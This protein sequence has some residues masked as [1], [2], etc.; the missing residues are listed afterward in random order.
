MFRYL[1][2]VIRSKH[3]SIK[4]KV[5]GILL[6]FVYTVP[7]ILLLAF[8]DLLALF[9]I[10]EM[11]IVSGVS[12]LIFVG[13]YNTFGNFAPFFQIGVATLLDNST[14]RVL[15][16]PLLLFNYFFNTWFI[17]IGFLGALVDIIT[18]RKSKWEKTERFRKKNQGLPGAILKLRGQNRD[19]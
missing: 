1:W 18:G 14:R 16:L 11:N 12:A 5:D 6:L 2:P 13:A 10:G 3:L 4:E 8:F 19:N 9:Y 15:L 17:A 7:L